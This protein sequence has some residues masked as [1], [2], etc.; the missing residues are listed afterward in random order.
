MNNT[1][2]EALEHVT[3]LRVYLGAGVA[4]FFLTAVTVTVAQIHLGEWNAIVAMTIASIKAVIVAFVFMHLLHDKKIFLMIFIT[5]V[6][7]LGIFLSLTMADVL[8]RGHVN[9]ETRMPIQEKSSMYDRMQTDSAAT[10]EHQESG[11]ENSGH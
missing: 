10:S 5:A 8:S 6:V 11:Q 1:K 9:V 3:P 2:S 4:L 7:F